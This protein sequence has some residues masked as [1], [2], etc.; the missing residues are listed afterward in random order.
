MSMNYNSIKFRELKSL[1]KSRG[2][3]KYSKLN[4]PSLIKLLIQ[5]DMIKNGYKPSI[6]SGSYGSYIL[7][8]PPSPV[9]LPDT[10]DNKSSV[11]DEDDEDSEDIPIL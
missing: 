1:V 6:S 3:K 4:K 9:I 8:P 11:D 5:D 10:D 2:I 7:P